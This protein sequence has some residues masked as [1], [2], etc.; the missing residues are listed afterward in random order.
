[1]MG[2]VLSG[3]LS[4]MG[5]GLVV[6]PATSRNKIRYY[7]TGFRVVAFGGLALVTFIYNFHR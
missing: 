4:C 5:T 3:E 7:F 6:M 1:M 2:K